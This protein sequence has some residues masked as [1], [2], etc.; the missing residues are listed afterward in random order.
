MAV[1]KLGVIGGSASMKL[2]GLKMEIGRLSKRRL[3]CRL[4][5]FSQAH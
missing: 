3:A 5:K 1:T 2:M 4:I